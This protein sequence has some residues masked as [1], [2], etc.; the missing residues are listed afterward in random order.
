MTTSV[1]DLPF[2]RKLAILPVEHLSEPESS[3]ASVPRYLT[4]S[5][6]GNMTKST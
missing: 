5:I 3:E 6:E 1:D 4:M 2:W